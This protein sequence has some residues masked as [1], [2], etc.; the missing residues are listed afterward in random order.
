MNG[1]FLK[2]KE[3]KEEFIMKKIELRVNY[4]A[5]ALPGEPYIRYEWFGLKDQRK[6]I[7]KYVYIEDEE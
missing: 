7:I 3:R 4:F 1:T 2:E 5:T 6:R